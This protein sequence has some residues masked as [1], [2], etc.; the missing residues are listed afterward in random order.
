MN[1]K[2]YEE[3]VQTTAFYPGANKGSKDAL[4]YAALGLAGESGEYTEKIKKFIRDGWFDPQAAMKELGDVLWYV[5]RC[6]NELG[7][8][9]ETVAL[10]NITKLQSRKERGTLQGS[11]DER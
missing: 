10:M 3:F 1:F 2:E 8:T 7:T 11:G 5:T 9:L 6:A 4:A